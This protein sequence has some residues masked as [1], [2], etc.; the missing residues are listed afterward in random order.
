MGHGMTPPNS[1][2]PKDLTPSYSSPTR[3]HL[4]YESIP[5][6]NQPYTIPMETWGSSPP[7]LDSADTRNHY[8]DQSKANANTK[9]VK[10]KNVQR[11]SIME[12]FSELH[13]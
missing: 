9:K 1:D 12:K 2:P 11:K 7:R 6:N 4:D 10:K 8:L 13:I 5:N 3:T